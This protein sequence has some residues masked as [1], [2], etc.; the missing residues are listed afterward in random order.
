MAFAQALQSVALPLLSELARF[1]E[2]TAGAPLETIA[3]K[4]F[5][6][7]TGPLDKAQGARVV[8]FLMFESRPKFQARRTVEEFA[9]QV[10]P[11]LPDETQKVLAGW[12]DAPRRLY[13]VDGWSGGFVTVV[14]LLEEDAAPK[15][16][17]DI[18]GSWQSASGE[19]AILRP[20]T[21][22]PG[23]DGDSFCAGRPLGFGGRPADDVVEAI[24]RRHFDFVRTE[25]I[26]R[27][28]DFLRLAPKALDEEAARR[29]LE[30]MIIVPG[31]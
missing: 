1:A 7:W 6:F 10:G 27:M 30:S 23:A 3:R 21:V 25:R 13:R 15:T 9:I 11:S 16:V 5:P 22:A 17:F 26:V 31:G 18:E 12:V 8:D 4:E 19:P 20:L 24:R 14:D 29:P 2:K 28:D